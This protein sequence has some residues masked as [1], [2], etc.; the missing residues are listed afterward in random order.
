M[1]VAGLVLGVSECYH[2]KITYYIIFQID[3]YNR[4][5]RI[6]IWRRWPS[7]NPYLSSSMEMP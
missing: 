2:F 5:G 1:Q 7:E 4:A 3:C 6:I